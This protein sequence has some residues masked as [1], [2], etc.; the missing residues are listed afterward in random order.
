MMGI[1]AKQS[2][3]IKDASTDVNLFESVFQQLYS[4][5]RLLIDM[6]SSGFFVTQTVAQAVVIL[7][8][9]YTLLKSFRSAEVNHSDY[10]RSLLGEVAYVRNSL[11][12]FVHII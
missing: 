5:Q 4:S 9:L 8:L 2:R 12:P 1:S 3:S 6:S 7:P 11:C 10:C